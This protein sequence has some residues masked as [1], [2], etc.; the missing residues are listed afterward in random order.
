MGN[1]D[2]GQC[3]ARCCRK[4]AVTHSYIDIE[5]PICRE[6]ADEILSKPPTEP[7]WLE[8]FLLWKEYNEKMGV[9]KKKRDALFHLPR[10]T[11]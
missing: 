11:A 2:K 9:I 4:R 1:R 5:R 8:A 7:L 6:C 10:R 3:A